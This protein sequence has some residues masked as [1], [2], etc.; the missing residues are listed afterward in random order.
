MGL[1]D[2]FPYTNF[3]ELNLMWILE[4]L[5]EIQT[6][7]EQFVAIN[8]LKY[9][10]PIQWN[11]TSQ[12]EKNTIVIDPQT[13]TA[14]I[15]V[16]PVPTGVA[17]TNEDY[18]TVVF[19][20]GAFVTRAA[21]N[22]TTRWE[23]DTTLTATFNSA[24][25]EWLVWGDTLYV[26]NVNIT[27]GD[28]YVVDGNIKRIT[29]EEVKN[30]V[31]QLIADNYNVIVAMIGDLN[32]LTTT[33]KDNIVTAINELVSGLSTE[34]QAREAADNAEAQAREAADTAL[35]GNINAEAQA[36]ED[37]DDVLRQLIL[38]SSSYYDTIQDLIDDTNVI[39]DK[40]CVVNGYHNSGDC[41]I[42][43]W[44]TTTT[45]TGDFGEITL[46]NGLYAH[47]LKS[48][49]KHF[50]VKQYGAY[51]DGVHDDYN[52]INDI[53]GVAREI[54]NS[55]VYLPAGKYLIGIYLN[56]LRT[57]E[58]AG[59]PTDLRN[60]TL[61][62][63]GENS[64]IYGH[65]TDMSHGCFDILQLNK[66]MNV[67]IKDLALTE[68]ITPTTWGANGISITN[69]GQNITIDN[70]H[71]YDLP[72]Y[73]GG[74]YI[75]GGKAFTIQTGSYTDV[76]KPI[77]NITIKNC[78]VDNTPY[79][80]ETDLVGAD[81]VEVN[82]ILVTDCVFNV[83]YAGVGL[84]M[85][86]PFYTKAYYMFSNLIITTKQFGVI[87]QR[88]WG[89][90]FNNISIMQIETPNPILASETNI[91]A[92]RLISAISCIFQNISATYNNG[93]DCVYMA[94][95][96]RTNT[97]NNLFEGLMCGGTFS[98]YMI[99]GANVN[100]QFPSDNVFIQCIG[101]GPAL[102]SISNLFISLY[103]AH[104]LIMQIAGITTINTDIQSENVTA[105]TLGTFTGACI[106]V[107]KANGSVQGYIPLYA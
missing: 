100:S 67:H 22:F 53:I 77:C 80:F 57:I 75:D 34:A 103:N 99:N 38:S 18:W 15:S 91:N 31:L 52:I 30:E 89:A 98:G 86:E 25:G 87:I 32:D 35:Q 101:G 73:T 90:K 44:A 47:L 85:S 84:G 46:N 62:G 82:N 83:L 74:G 21:K 55:V 5:K 79:G 20:L 66:V 105:H 104:N 12:Y 78:K 64:I 28:S 24:A 4:A 68:D 107:L 33:A 50:N 37:A 102:G 13:G 76:T 54:D 36:R 81:Q 97:R 19:D 1:F 26:A 41:D 27:A 60:L 7:T 14:Y 92:I 59:D 43:I 6:T 96:G 72:Y 16:Q 49:P 63:D 106:K 8:S 17:L 71:V 56:N 48:N 10:D 69:G 58:S 93:Q 3:H 51:G 94:S 40:N 39:A 88:F 42:M 29:I 23:A 61:C 65:E 45:A 70:V 9:A 11:I 2:Q 95:D